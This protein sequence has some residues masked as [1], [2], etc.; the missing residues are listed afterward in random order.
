MSDKIK[1]KVFRYDPKRDKK[2]NFQV[3]KVPANE[4]FSILDVLIYIYEHYDGSLA[5]RYSCKMGKCG[6]CTV[7]ANK[8]PVCACRTLV[9]DGMIIEPLP[10]FPVI[11]DLVVDYKSY[12]NL[13]KN[14]VFVVMKDAYK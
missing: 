2:P 10:N 11:R 9:E 14:L 12:E 3:Y 4:T 13:R 7:L 8:K 1:V 5:F 6:S